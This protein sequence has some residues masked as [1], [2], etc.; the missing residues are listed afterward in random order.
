MQH[1]VVLIRPRKL[2]CSS[3]KPVEI[4]KGPWLLQSRYKGTTI[5]AETG[6]LLFG[7]GRDRDHIAKDP[8]SAA[9]RI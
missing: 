8:H 3:Q 6:K 1:H 7:P 5:A 2:T 9:S 4:T